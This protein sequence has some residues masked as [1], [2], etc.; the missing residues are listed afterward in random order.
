L[1]RRAYR[2][3]ET[4]ADIATLMK[5]YALGRQGSTFDAG[6]ET[7]VQR[8]LADPKFV[9]RVESAPQGL[10]AGT[11]YRVSDLDLASRLSFFLWSSI[12]DDELLTLA[13]KGELHKPAVLREQLRRMLRDPKSHT[14]VNNFAGQWLQ[15][16]NVRNVLPNSDDFP[17]F[18]DN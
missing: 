18:D 1:A 14:L 9:F 8:L 16:R 10:P 13:K 5:F 4:P 7:L 2:G 6:I 12:P 15:L 17:D 11:P 3:F